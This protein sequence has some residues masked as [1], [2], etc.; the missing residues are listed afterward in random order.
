MRHDGLIF[1][2]T[3]AAFAAACSSPTSSSELSREINALRAST[4]RY[5]SFDAAV[6]DSYATKLTD[7]MVDTSLGGMGVHYAKSSLIDGSVS[8]TTP[9]VLLYEPQTDGSLQLV[10][11]EYIIPYTLRSRSATPPVL[12]GQQFKQ[13]DAFQLWGL[14]A[15][16]WRNNPSGLFA[17]WNPTVHCTQ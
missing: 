4:S 2:L 9:Q 10:A 7:C 5:H 16:V 13:N 3:A 12:F 14:H 6:A 11:V 15:W 1:A 17:D 8:V